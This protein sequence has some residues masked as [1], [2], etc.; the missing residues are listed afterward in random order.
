[1]SARKIQHITYPFDYIEVPKRYL[2]CQRCNEKLQDADTSH[3]DAF[4]KSKEI[5]DV[6]LVR[7][8]LLHAIEHCN[9]DSV[10][11]I[12]TSDNDFN[13]TIIAL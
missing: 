6:K 4:T 1:M 5:A 2:R 8:I 11:L 13:K 12:V 7:R 10:I 9:S 3:V